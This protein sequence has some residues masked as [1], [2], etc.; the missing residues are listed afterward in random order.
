MKACYNNNSVLGPGNGFIAIDELADFP[1]L[2]N[3]LEAEPERVQGLYQQV[4]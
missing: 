3:L 2:E 1:T 4:L